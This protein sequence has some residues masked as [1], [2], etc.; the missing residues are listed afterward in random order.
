MKERSMWTVV[1]VAL[2][3]A[4]VVSIVTVSITG[5]FIKQNN[6]NLGQYKIYTTSEVYNKN[7]TDARLRLYKGSCQYVGYKD[8]TSTGGS[9]YGMNA[10]DTC[11]TFGG[12]LPKIVVTSRSEELYNSLSCSPSY[13]IFR[14]YSESLQSYGIDLATARLG[15]V[16]SKDCTNASFPNGKLNCNF[17]EQRVLTYVGVLCCN[18]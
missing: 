13:L 11:N 1:G 9:Y 2:F 14:S 7:E 18:N 12:L 10:R 8:T 17:S 5:N 15:E 6:N 3:I 16:A 4:I